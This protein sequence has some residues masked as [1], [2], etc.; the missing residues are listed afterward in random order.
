[1]EGHCESLQAIPVVGALTYRLL[2]LAGA[3]LS[4]FPDALGMD[5]PELTNHF[6]VLR[7]DSEI[8]TG[9]LS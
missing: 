8:Q 2:R 4:R 5:F 6:F 9:A 3:R 1:M 7:R